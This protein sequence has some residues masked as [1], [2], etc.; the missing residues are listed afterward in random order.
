MVIT[1]SDGA[2]AITQADHA[3]MCAQLVD[4]WGSPRFGSVPRRDELR[5]AASQHELGWS[6]LDAQPP[7]DLATGLPATV[8]ALP[9]DRYISGQLEGPRRLGEQA[10]Y[11]GLA[12][13]L[14][15]ASLY[16]RPGVVGLLSPRGRLLRAFFAEAQQLQS[17]LADRAGVSL[18]DP[19]TL[20]AGRLVRAWDGLSHDLLLER[21]PC[22]RR[23]PALDGELVELRLER[24]R[25]AIR[26]SPWPFAERRVEIS[27]R[28][29]LLT[30]TFDSADEMHVALAAA[31]AVT[32]RYLLIA[33]DA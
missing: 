17:E 15:H 19:E 21:A 29:R 18:A 22:T 6:E 1:H 11:A 23:V 10:P 13:S 9:F 32:L 14:H 7:L 26:V 28:G 12:A 16:E 8:N 30:K 33:D 31:P 25:D 2:V 5:L 24:D 27:V 20:R 3:K 4:A